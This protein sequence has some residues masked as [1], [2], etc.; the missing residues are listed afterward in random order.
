M[1]YSKL[2]EQVNLSPSA[3][4]RRIKVLEERGIIDH[5]T[6]I[7]NARAMGQ[8]IRAFVSLKVNRHEVDLVQQF[9]D[10]VV[11]YPEVISCHQLT[12]QNDFILEVC[13]LDLDS[14][15]DFI[16]KK[17]LAVPVVLDASSSIVLKQ[18]KIHQTEILN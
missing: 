15:A 6:V 3:C 8:Q 4:L 18:I 12:G 1:S 13:S 9:L 2:A 17:I 7:L 14:Y 16:N 11:A 10:K 5:F